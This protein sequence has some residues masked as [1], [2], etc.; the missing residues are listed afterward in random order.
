MTAQVSGGRA[1]INGIRYNYVTQGKDGAPWITFS[2]SLA[3]DLH[4]W[5]PQIDALAADYRIL[6]YHFRATVQLASPR[7]PT[8]WL[9]SPPMPS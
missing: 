9:C 5:D 7:R 6:R 2:N 3:T 4:L 8:I 1:E